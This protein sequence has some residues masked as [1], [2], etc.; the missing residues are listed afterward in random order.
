[1]LYNPLNKLDFKKLKKENKKRFRREIH[2]GKYLDLQ[3]LKLKDIKNIDV[4]KLE[5]MASIMR[6]LIFAT[7]ETAQSGHPGGSSGKVEQFLG[8]TMSGVMAFDP[9]DPKNT[10]RDRVVWSAG[11]CT[12]GLYSG[13]TLIY[14]SLKKSGKKFNKKKLNA[15]L[16]DDLLKFRKSD[17][18]QGHVESYSPL[19]DIST[20]PSG[21]GLPAAGGLAISHKSSG[22]DTN[23]WVFMGDAESEEGLSYEARNISHKVGLDNLIVSLSYNHFGI[24]GAIE[25]VI[26]TPYINHWLGLGWNVI[27]IDGH[28]IMECIYAYKLA[29]AKVFRNGN[30]T[31]ILAHTLKG[32]LYGSVENSEKSHGSPVKHEE[33]YRV[34]KNLGFDIPGKKGEVKK[35]I[36]VVL[37]HLDKKLAKYIVG[38]LEVGK[39]NIKTTKQLK[40]NIKKA[41]GKRPLK[42]PTAIKKPT[43]LPKELIFQE[44]EEIATRKATQA[45]F[46]WMIKK[47]AFFYAGA[48]DLSKSVLTS[49]AEEN[50]GLITRDNPYGRGI[51][52]GIAEPNMAM[53]STAMT[54][55]RLP[56]GY[57]PVSVFGT[58]GYLL[59]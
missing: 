47:S 1:M 56:G 3:G 22:L 17:G 6:G 33:Y 27:E 25:E 43:K 18:P 4:E 26:S 32:K 15:I 36:E 45:F 46:D 42:S 29:K 50:Y 55:D 13:L 53:M 28:N 52:Y 38:R 35:D 58:Y 23:V 19:A 54:A 14:E 40:S 16:A 49:K 57:A 34:M 12:P 41:L 8:M 7:V 51:R 59:L 31:V 20:G 21:H 24:D 39:K 9:L 30:P 2:G 10:G 5:K 48:G 37:N 44:G 11:H